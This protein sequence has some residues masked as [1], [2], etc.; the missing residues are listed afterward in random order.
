[1]T[2]F[3]HYEW[4]TAVFFGLTFPMGFDE[5]WNAI[6]TPQRASL[7]S[8]MSENDREKPALIPARGLQRPVFHGSLFPKR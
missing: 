2:Y 6:E 4:L 5:F 8:S 1:M 3:P 7:S